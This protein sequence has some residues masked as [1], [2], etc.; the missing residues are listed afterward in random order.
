V[1]VHSTVGVPLVTKNVCCRSLP[2]SWANMTNLSALWLE[3]NQ[4]SGSLPDAW[5][6]N[7][8]F[9][10]LQFLRLVR[11]RLA[12]A[13]TDLQV[14]TTCVRCTDDMHPDPSSV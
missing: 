13:R 10:K 5:G 8:S 3:R 6:A 7:S 4:L 11:H 1:T 12:Q 9:P 14:P 2:P